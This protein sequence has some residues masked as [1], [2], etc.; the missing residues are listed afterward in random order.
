MPQRGGKASLAVRSRGGW[1]LRRRNVALAQ[2]ISPA[3]DRSRLLYIVRVRNTEGGDWATLVKAGRMS[4]RLSQLAL[5]KAVGISRETVWRWETGRQKPENAEVVG[6]LAKAIHQDYDELMRAAGLA[7][8]GP[9]E[10]PEPDPRLRGLDPKD[11]VVVT[12]LGLDIS[13][14]RKERM[15]NRR[16]KILE[17]RRRADLEELEFLI[18]PGTDAV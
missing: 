13:D 8:A 15:L 2:H 14:V 18:D 7:L 3:Q 4:V 9:D 17:E 10:A 5:A 6:R 12:I 16:R 11:P 1:A